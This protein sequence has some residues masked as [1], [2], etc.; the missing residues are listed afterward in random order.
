MNPNTTEEEEKNDPECMQPETVAKSLTVLEWPS[1]SWDLNPIE[2]LER[3][4]NDRSQTSSL[5]E[6]DMICQEK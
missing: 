4:E 6:I 3:P 1:Y 2:D 5:M